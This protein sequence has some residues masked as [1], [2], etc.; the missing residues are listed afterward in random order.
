MRWGRRLSKLPTVSKVVDIE[1]FVPDDQ[2]AKLAI[3]R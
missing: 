2:Q 3:D 1:S